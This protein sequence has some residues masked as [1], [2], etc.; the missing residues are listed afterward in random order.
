MLGSRNRSG[1]DSST[2]TT[3]TN[4]NLTNHTAVGDYLRS[5]LIGGGQA[6]SQPVT[7]PQLL[8]QQHLQES[9]KY[10]IQQQQQ[11]QQQQQ[12]QNILQRQ[13]E[14]TQSVFLNQQITSEIQ[15][16]LL[17]QDRNQLSLSIPTMLTTM[18]NVTTTPGHII[19]KKNE[20]ESSSASCMTPSANSSG[21]SHP[22]L[23]TTCY[24]QHESIFCKAAIVGMIMF[25][26]HAMRF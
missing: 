11:Q 5:R 6:T 23:S 18:T 26:F 4:T 15:R 22:G 21:L 12:R 9:L 17:Q 16:R 8:Q 10:L 25:D 14:Q 1:E 19:G 2:K 7:P 24:M 13:S 3:T 20:P